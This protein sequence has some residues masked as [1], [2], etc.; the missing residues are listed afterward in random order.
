MGILKI[1]SG[2]KNPRKIPSK[3]LLQVEEPE[4]CIWDISYEESLEVKAEATTGFIKQEAVLTEVPTIKCETHPIQKI[5]QDSIMDTVE[6]GFGEINTLIK[7]C[8]KP[9]YKTPLYKESFLSEFK[10]ESEKQKVR[11][12]LGVYSKQDINKII[13]EIIANDSGTFITKQEVEQL[14]AN[15]DFVDSTLK[16]QVNYDIPNNLF[17][18]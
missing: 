17:K 3:S 7:D 8:P 1:K 10:N 16:A 13:S 14:I 15:L 18:L 2:D 6:T 5:R 9:K 12:N 11:D 4:K